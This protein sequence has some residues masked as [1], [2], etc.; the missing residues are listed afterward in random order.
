[1]DGHE[2]LVGEF[3]ARIG[4][5]ETVVEETLRRSFFWGTLCFEALDECVEVAFEVASSV[6]D[7]WPERQRRVRRVG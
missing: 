5:G 7:I 2:A 6:V 3:V 4:L 1:M